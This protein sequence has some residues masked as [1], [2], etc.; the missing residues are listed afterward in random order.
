MKLEILQVP[1]CPNVGLLERRIAEA[2]A[3]E[4]IDVAITHRVLNDQAAATEAR[5]TGSP[6]LLVDGED[7]FTEPG[8]VAGVSCRLYPVEGG[9]IDG[10]PSVAALRAA[11]NL[12]PRNA[13]I[14]VPAGGPADCCVPAAGDISCAE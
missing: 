10:A 7:P 5:M 11:L 4:Q 12:A 6:T 2:V 14:E 13:S 3:G 9:G 8:S 1:G